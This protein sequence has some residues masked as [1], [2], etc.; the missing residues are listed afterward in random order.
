MTMYFAILFLKPSDLVSL[1]QTSL[2]ITAL[3]GRIFL[4]ERLT[5]GHFIAILL[6]IS[7][8]VLISKPS[9]FFAKEEMEELKHAEQVVCNGTLNNNN[10]NTMIA[11]ECAE[12]LDEEKKIFNDNLKLA[13]GIGLTFV[14]AFS[15]SCVFLV[16]KKLNNSKVHWASNTIFVCWFGIPFSLLISILLYKLGYSHQNLALE[17]KDLPMDLFYSVLSSILSVVG[18]ILL[19]KCLMYEDATKIAIT[20]TTDVLFTTILQYFILNIVIDL[21]SAVGA[22]NIM[23]GSFFIL[24]F[25][26][27]EDKYERFNLKQTAKYANTSS[28][29]GK[30]QEDRTL[31]L[32]V[33]LTTDSDASNKVIIKNENDQQNKRPSSLKMYILKFIFLKY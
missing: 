4:K 14:S 31:I 12:I 5:L 24:V 7:G 9:I 30:D 18:Q 32:K 22:F 8:V 29:T 26:L 19:N 20:R 21:L 28:E 33:N 11:S 23:M 27:F 13:L 2:V 25:K 3:L 17:K 15:T 1:S 6:T 16:L 10:N